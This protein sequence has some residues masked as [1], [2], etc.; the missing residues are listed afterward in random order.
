VA[1][2]IAG[3]A[4]PLESEKKSHELDDPAGWVDRYGDG[5]L[6]FALNRV[7][8]RDTAED[9]VQDAFL[10]AWKSRDTFDGR[11]SLGTWLCGILRRKIADHYRVVGRKRRFVEQ[12]VSEMDKPLFDKRGKWR[13]SLARWTESPEQLQQ[14]HEFWEVMANCLASLPANLADSFRLREIHLMSNEETCISTGVTPKN[15]A[16]R[17]HR[18]RLL[19]RRC[20]DQKWFRGGV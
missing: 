17:L 16:V 20:L 18:A 5:L 14:N 3:E 9:L 1:A 19:L 6:R 8:T 10:A 2:R 15:L 13:E 4:M 12:A 11:S 7:G